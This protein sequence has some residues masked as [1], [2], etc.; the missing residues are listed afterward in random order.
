[1][2]AAEEGSASAAR[3]MNAVFGP[4]L[5]AIFAPSQSFATLKEKPLQALWV[6]LW[7]MVLTAVASVLSLDVTRQFMRIGFVE[8]LSRGDQQMGFLNRDH[9]GISSVC[10]S[11]GAFRGVMR[12]LRGLVGR[13]RVKR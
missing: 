3:G 13:L 10:F 12:G 7:V 1:M 2:H 4:T 11:L 9:D 6:V 5:N 8:R